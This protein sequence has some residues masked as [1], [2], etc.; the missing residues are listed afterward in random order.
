MSARKVIH[1]NRIRGP[2]AVLA[3]FLATAG[4]AGLVPFAP[5]TAG[6][7]VGVPISYWSCEWDWPARVALWV[8]LIVVGTWAAAV[9]DELMGTGDNQHIVIDEVIGLGIS[10][11]TAGKDPRELVAAFVLFRFFDIVKPWPVRMI[12]RWSKKRASRGDRFAS[13]YGGFGVI[14]DDVA[15]GFQA[16]AVMLLLQ[17]WHLLGL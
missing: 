12:D 4:G 15:A 11:W 10:A 13:W 9:F 7:A 6:T 1:W 2:R 8:A 17:H 16:L 5:G 3:V 14:A